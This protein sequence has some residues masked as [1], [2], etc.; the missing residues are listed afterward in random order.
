MTRLADSNGYGCTRRPA[1]R[2]AL[3][4]LALSGMLCWAGAPAVAPAA[5]TRQARP[6]ASPE[7]AAH[8]R[9]LFLSVRGP[10]ARLGGGL[11]SSVG[12]GSEDLAEDASPGPEADRPKGRKWFNA[13]VSWVP[14]S[15]LTV[16]ASY[17]HLLLV[18]PDPGE[19]FPALGAAPEVA[20]PLPPAEGGG[21]ICLRAALRF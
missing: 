5:D 15:R 16:S 18:R 14:A 20:P 6:A 9:D 11:R 7:I 4:S 1:V 12:V 8:W 17:S 13:T 3:Q 10:S 19:D 21:I 2:R